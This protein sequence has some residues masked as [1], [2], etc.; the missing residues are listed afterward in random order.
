MYMSIQRQSPGKGLLVSPGL[1][2]IDRGE[3]AKAPP[4]C[5]DAAES[6]F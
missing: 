4:G 3:Q 2:D 1:T 5:G 6:I